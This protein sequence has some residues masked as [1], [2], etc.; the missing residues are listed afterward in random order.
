MLIRGCHRRVAVRSKELNSLL[1][2]A[3]AADQVFLVRLQKTSLCSTAFRDRFFLEKRWKVLFLMT[4]L[5]R[6]DVFQG[7]VGKKRN[8]V[9]K[10]SDPK[11][12]LMLKKGE[13]F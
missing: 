9:N 12:Q 4:R 11:F 2:S 13:S 3:I 6:H 7:T 8:P 1:Y 5:R 10:L